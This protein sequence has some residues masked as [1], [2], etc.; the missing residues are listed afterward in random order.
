MSYRPLYVPL[1]PEAAEK[2][3]LLAIDERRSPKQHAAHLLERV[4]NQ[5]WALRQVDIRNRERRS[6]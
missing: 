5:R 3:R 6:A 1:S 4:I 2:L